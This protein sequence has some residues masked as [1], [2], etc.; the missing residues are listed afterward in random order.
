M[1]R[2]LVALMLQMSCLS[3]DLPYRVT[4]MRVR[5]EYNEFTLI[6]QKE[7]IR[8]TKHVLREWSRAS[9]RR[10]KLVKEGENVRIRVTVNDGVFGSFS[11]VYVSSGEV[12]LALVLLNQEKI[13]FAKNLRKVLLHEFG[14][15]LGLGHNSDTESVM[16]S[17]ILDK[18][19]R[20]SKQD[21]LNA[22]NWRTQ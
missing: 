6:D 22:R 9:G 4:H 11:P 2:Y 5:I 20:I 7:L 14:H 19:Y 15:C 3:A 10:H 16:Y 13:W 17:S 1:M 21:R 12:Q 18:Q 8:V